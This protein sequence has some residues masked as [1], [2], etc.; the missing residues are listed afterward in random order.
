M[1]NR[2]AQGRDHGLSALDVFSFGVLLY[3]MA[4][5]QPPFTGATSGVIFEAILNRAPA[6]PAVLNP[7]VSPKLAE[8][9]TKALEKDRRLRYQSASEK[10]VDLQRLKRD[11]GSARSE[12]ASA[13]SA[14]GAVPR[15]VGAPTQKGVT[16]AAPTESS[17]DAQ[18]V[19][20]LLKRHKL[21][22]AGSER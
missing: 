8:I 20:G 7:Q 19:V 3:E 6:P 13:A 21:G 11:S 18:I 12:V 16:P 10:R 14:A 15:A 9:I 17:S 1:R 2:H 5:G 22:A 4:T